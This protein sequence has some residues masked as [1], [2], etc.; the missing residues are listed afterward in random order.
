MTLLHHPE[1]SANPNAP[2]LR[3]RVTAHDQSRVEW[4]CTVP[5]APPGVTHNYQVVMEFAVPE[6]IWVPHDPWQRYQVRTRLTSPVLRADGREPA[7]SDPRDRLRLR[8]LSV[9]HALRTSGRALLKPIL[10]AH[11]RDGVLTQ[12]EAERVVAA[13]PVA[14]QPAHDHRR[15]LEGHAQSE[16]ASLEREALL[17]DEYTSGHVL[18]LLTRARAA[19]QLPR[20]RRATLMSGATAPVLEALTAALQAEHMHRRQKAMHQPA[21]HAPAEVEAYLNRA[22][23]LK[24]HFQ[25][26]LFLDATA[27]MLD[28]RLRNWIAA[29]MAMVAAVFYFAWQISVLNA[30]T[31]GATT[32]SLALAGVVGALVYAAKDRIKEVGRSWLAEKLKHTYADRVARL[33]LQERMDPE[34]REFVLA[35]ETITVRRYLEPDHFNPELGRTTPVQ[36]MRIRERLRHTGVAQLHEQGLLGLKH[37][38][39][40]D[41]SPLLAKL[42]DHQ[43]HVPVLGPQGVTLR[44][45]SRVYVLPVTVRLTRHQIDGEQELLC[46]TGHLLLRGRR[47]VRFVPS[48]HASQVTGHAAVRDVGAMALRANADEFG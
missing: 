33:S 41:L 27:F 4:I 15:W 36:R 10:E 22:A 14:L 21:P 7:A 12:E 5:M 1:T 31:T 44:S 11:H 29:A 18:L 40:Y 39:R 6:T 48:G 43:K 38:F 20:M 34:R 3:L 17:A 13:L 24:K 30:V 9:A 42:D 16:D 28:E 35:L 37:V 45:G 47:L 8:A 23:Q 26:A 46:Q 25:Q 32:V 19:L 2:P